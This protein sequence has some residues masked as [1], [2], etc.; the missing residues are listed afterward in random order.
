M[1]I[2]SVTMLAVVLFAA[3]ALGQVPHLLGYQGRLL[4][5]D[6]TAATGTASVT[7]TVHDSA[8]GGKGVLPLSTGPQPR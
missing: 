4:R 5:A 1:R 6:G 2:R 3:P 8:S 7:F